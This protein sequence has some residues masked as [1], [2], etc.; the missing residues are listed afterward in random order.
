MIRKMDTTRAPLTSPILISSLVL[1]A[2]DNP[3]QFTA[4]LECTVVLGASLMTGS[5]KRSVK[6]S[7]FHNLASVPKN[8]RLVCSR[9][10]L[11]QEKKKLITEIKVLPWVSPP[12]SILCLR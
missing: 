2:T 10:H 7:W 11:K 5:H 3:V 8:S 1:L 12:E 6:L 4:A 9:K